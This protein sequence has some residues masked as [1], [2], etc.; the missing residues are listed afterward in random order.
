[1][2]PKRDL[3]AN[4]DFAKVHLE[5]RGKVSDKW[6]FYLQEYE[7]LLS[8][9]RLKDISLLE[10]GIQNGGSLDIWNKYFSN[11]N[12]IVGCDID[13]KCSEL[14]YEDPKIHVVVGDILKKE[15]Q[16]NIIV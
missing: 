16:N 13:L 6:S 14:F 3:T 2:P 8:P 7:R 12:S 10:I 4:N 9:M 15:T 1:M 11:S 5:H